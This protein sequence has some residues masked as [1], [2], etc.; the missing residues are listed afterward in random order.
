M[1]QKYLIV[2]ME[3]GLVVLLLKYQ[4]GQEALPSIS[5]IKHA[6]K[7]IADCTCANISP[8]ERLELPS[9]WTSKDN[10]I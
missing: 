6:P 10:V 1:I 7:L 5:L 4:Y 2:L 8:P 3:E 9:F